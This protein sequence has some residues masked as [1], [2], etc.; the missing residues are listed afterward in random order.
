MKF[1][2]VK[3]LEKMMKAIMKMLSKIAFKLTHLHLLLIVIGVLLVCSIFRG[4]L[5]EGM[6][7][8]EHIKDIAKKHGYDGSVDNSAEKEKEEYNKIK[9]ETDKLPKR[10]EDE[11]DDDT[12]GKYGSVKGKSTHLSKHVKGPHGE[13]ILA[14]PEN[15]VQGIPKSQIPPGQDDLYILKSEIVPPVCPACPSNAVCPREKPCSPC[16]PCARC[17]EPAFE[18]KKVPNYKASMGPKM[19]PRAVLS[20]FSQFGL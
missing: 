16:P 20:D 19:E 18:C 17:P 12:L 15:T 10:D 9:E 7:E 6:S 13:D 11:G 3:S 2:I 5:K 14:T 8:G 4:C 1:G